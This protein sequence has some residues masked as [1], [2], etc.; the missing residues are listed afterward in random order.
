MRPNLSSRRPGAGPPPADPTES[1][2]RKRYNVPVRMRAWL[3]KL[4]RVIPRRRRRLWRYVSG[5]RRGA[6]LGAFALLVLIAYGY[7][8]FT[9][10]ARVQQEFIRYLSHLTGGQVKVDRTEFSLFEGIRVTNL[11]LYLPGDADVPF[12]R[13]PQVH[14]SHR[15]SALLLR[16]KLVPTEIVCVKPRV[17]LVEDVLTERLNVEKIFPIARRAAGLGLGG[18]LPQIRLREAE[19]EFLDLEDG[20][21]LPVGKRPLPWIVALLPG[22]EGRIYHVSFEGQA[23]TIRGS[24]TIDTE[25]GATRLSGRLGLHGLDK[26]LPRKYRTWRRRYGLAG[27]VHYAGV[28]RLGGST[29]SE[30]PGQLERLKVELKDVSMKLPRE[31]G[32]LSLVGVQGRLIFSGSQVSIERLSGCIEHTGGAAFTLS[33]VYRGYEP[34]SPFEVAFSV[35][36]LSLPLGRQAVSAWPEAMARIHRQLGLEGPVSIR[37]TVKRDASGE[38]DVDALAKLE[39]VGLRLPGWP[40]RLEQVTGQIVMD[41]EDL[42]LQGLRGLRGQ[43]EVELSGRLSA[44]G[45][46]ADVT[47]SAHKLALTEDLRDS[48][49]AKLA[50]VWDDLAPRGVADLHLRLRQAPGQAAPVDL[51]L[52]VNLKGGASMEFVGFPYRL[53]DLTGQLYVD[54]E[55]AEIRSVRGRAGR[56]RCVLNGRVGLSDGPGEYEI[57]IEATDV[58]LD[59]RLAAALPDQARPAYEACGLNGRVDVTG[60]VVRRRGGQPVDFEVPLTLKGVGFRHRLFPYGFEDVTGTALI[61]PRT[62]RIEHVGA[63]HGRGRIS[64]SGRFPMPNVSDGWELKAEA[65]DLPLDQEL[66]DALPASIQAGW[67]LIRP[68]GSADASV[69]LRVPAN[70]EDAPV[71]YR[72][73]VRPRRAG[74]RYRDFPYPLRR[75]GGVVV[76]TP[77]KVTLDGLSGRAGSAE[78]V[79]DGEIRTWPGQEQADLRI[80][81]GPIDIDG[82]L[83][84]ALPKPLV[85]TLRLRRGGAA[86]LRIEHLRVGRAEASSAEPVEVPASRTARSASATRPLSVFRTAELSTRPKVPLAWSWSGRITLNDAAMG[87]GLGGKRF[88]GYVEGRMACAGPAAALSISADAVLDEVVVGGRRLGKFTARLRKERRSPVLRVDDISGRAYGGRVAGFA[89]ARL[90]SPARYGLSLSVEDID[91]AKFLAEGRD[92]QGLDFKGLLTG[93]LEMTGV[94]GQPDSR[95]AKGKLRIRRAQLYRLP[96]LLGFLHVIYLKLPSDSAFHTA[97]VNYGK[98]KLTF[99]TGP[100][101]KLPGIAGLWD[102]IDSLAGELMA[103]RVTGTLS[104]PKVEPVAVGNIKATLRELF[105]GT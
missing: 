69:T 21:L 83:L 70:G 56:M 47:F 26:A 4:R 63:G 34:D 43:A 78:V 98:L 25:T 61:T 9:N 27:R 65:S 104:K 42:M 105:G 3:L 35:S 95:W 71:Q 28:G 74:A 32:G 54:R 16:G 41:R 58:A 52:T 15:P 39:G 99:L 101:R 81:T 59:E 2:A 17:T 29:T 77:G 51:V 76:M 88:T 92:G 100:P 6:G 22:P 72:L 57:F 49:P 23:G 13:A 24:G 37:A 68:D 97:E 36:E 66:R 11:R 82:Q 84:A 30:A 53:N 31:E 8:L 20:Q 79:L 44:T 33:G 40:M 12:L 48:L 94:A 45:A 64:L 96:V 90:A 80:S 46:G 67:D 93:N 55:G 91:L 86:S 14:L 60:A 102:A 10:D 62:A 89:E 85:E 1:R 38:L 18:Q 103:V 5:R 75:V 87:L 7:W 50:K 73:K 19:L